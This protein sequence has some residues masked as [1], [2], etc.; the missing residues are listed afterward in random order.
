MVHDF[1]VLS[2]F[3]KVVLVPPHLPVC[4]SSGKNVTQTG[5]IFMK[6]CDMYSNF[7]TSV[8]FG[9][10]KKTFK[11]QVLYDD[12]LVKCRQDVFSVRYETGV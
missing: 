12:W 6:F 9:R 3:H 4:L 7:S 1:D 10:H 8:D 5:R 11:N 2:Q